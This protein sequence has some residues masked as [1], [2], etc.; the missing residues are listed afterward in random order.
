MVLQKDILVHCYEVN[1]EKGRFEY[2]LYR[3]RK[4]VDCKATDKEAAYAVV[5]NTTGDNVKI[6]SLHRNA[7][8]FDTRSFDDPTVLIVPI[9]RVA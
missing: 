9:I 3:N 6:D 5:T 2:R 8:S 7:S 4:R 1:R